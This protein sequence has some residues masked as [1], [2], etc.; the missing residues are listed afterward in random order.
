MDERIA[1]GSRPDD[2]A[3]RP[4]SALIRRIRTT[5]ASPERL[6]IRSLLTLMVETRL[7]PIGEPISGK[8]ATF[9]AADIN[10]ADIANVRATVDWDNGSSTIAV[11]KDISSGKYE[12]TIP[13]DKGFIYPPPASL[14]FS[15]N[16]AVRLT[17]IDT[18]KDLAQNTGTV[19]IIPST[20]ASGTTIRAEQNVDFSGPV[21]YF[22]DS[23]GTGAFSA[24]INWGDGT[25][26]P[27][28]IVKVVDSQFQVNGTH[29]YR[30]QPGVYPVRITVYEPNAT[31]PLLTIDSAANVTSSNLEASFQGRLA[32][33]S[34]TGPSDSD[35]ITRTP[36]PVFEGNAV[37]YSVVLLYGR[38]FD[39]KQEVLL[40]RT[41]AG[42]DGKWQIT[43]GPL[44]DGRYV[45]TGSM[46]TPS[47]QVVQKTFCPERPTPTQAGPLL[48][49]TVGVAVVRIQRID[50]R[51]SPLG[52]K[53][54]S[55]MINLLVYFEPD[56][57][58]LDPSSLV[59]RK[60]Y[61]LQQRF[62]ENN[63]LKRPEVQNDDGRFA[64]F[65][66][67]DL[68]F[69]KAEVD[70]SAKLRIHGVQDMAGNI[71]SGVFPT[72]TRAYR[73]RKLPLR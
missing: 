9:D 37:P 25:S 62:H 67:V 56:F 10:S 22:F 69:S 11:I 49:D 6:E 15:R 47:G 19:V 32:P 43:A 2:R 58:G 48:I 73:T 50:T 53:P 33:T 57:S 21:G 64:D 71:L 39:Y 12:V 26:S 44:A 59:D 29:R 38:R 14:P 24:I 60:N 70:N 34:D 23:K 65:V 51:M 72:N 31:V 16:Y 68:Q 61:A 52:T 66:R 13:A 40:G 28:Q 8:V 30:D 63:P 36:F 18:G 41:V 54:K 46:T 27:G 3:F 35:N 20:S 55:G 7:V 42:P 45:I 5:L 1:S 17:A 4:Q